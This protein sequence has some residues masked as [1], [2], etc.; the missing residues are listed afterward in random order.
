[1]QHDG[2]FDKQG[3]TKLAE[4]PP[5]PPSERNWKLKFPSAS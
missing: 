1:M 5:L 2:S 3:P 4:L